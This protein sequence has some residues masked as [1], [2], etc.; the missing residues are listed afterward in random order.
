MTE[1]QTKIIQANPCHDD[2]SMSL[3]KFAYI[4][5]C[6]TDSIESENIH[7]HTGRMIGADN[8]DLEE[9]ERQHM[10]QKPKIESK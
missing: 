7:S 8:T 1:H 5:G 10:E 2:F 3:K 9:K 6:W 4:Y